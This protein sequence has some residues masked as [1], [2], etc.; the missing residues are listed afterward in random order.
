MDD[1]KSSLYSHYKDNESSNQP[2][3]NIGEDIPEGIF[4]NIKEIFACNI[5]GLLKAFE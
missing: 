4:S 5:N 2:L 3:A 1:I